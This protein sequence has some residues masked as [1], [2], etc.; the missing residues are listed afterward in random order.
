MI[1]HDEAIQQ[2]VSRAYGGGR[3]ALPE[4]DMRRRTPPLLMF[5]LR[6]ETLRRVS[7][8]CVL[9]TLD[10]IGVVGALYTAML[11]KLGLRDHLDLHAAW[12][13]IRP[14]VTFAYLI[15]GAVLTKW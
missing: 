3:L 8:V 6:R 15:T 1:D 13:Y 2:R 10:F 7:R 5:L 12:H 4:R 9:L 14:S 11:I